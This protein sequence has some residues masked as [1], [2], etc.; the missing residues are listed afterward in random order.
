MKEPTSKF[1]GDHHEIKSLEEL[2]TAA[3]YPSIFREFVRPG[4]KVEELLM[5]TRLTKREAHLVTIALYKAEKFELESFKKL[6]LSYLAV[7]CSV[8]G[9]SRKELLQA[10]VGMLVPAWGAKEKAER[11]EA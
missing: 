11:K 2:L 8:N 10:A 4:D 5:R 9:M 3:E 6:L 1:S 7:M